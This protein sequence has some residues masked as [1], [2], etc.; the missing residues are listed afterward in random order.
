MSKTS[1]TNY[2]MCI[3]SLIGIGALTLTGFYRYFKS[4]RKIIP[5]IYN[6]LQFSKNELTVENFENIL[7]MHSNQFM[8]SKAMEEILPREIGSE[9][10]LKNL[11]NNLKYSVGK[12]D[13]LSLTR[14]RNK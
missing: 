10:D 2:K 6:P 9:N 8:Q 11:S 4:A 13:L 14:V 1:E 3:F 7:K 12:N 5:K